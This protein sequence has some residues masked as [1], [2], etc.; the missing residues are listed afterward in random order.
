MSVFSTIFN[1]SARPVL[2]EHLASTVTALFRV[3]GRDDVTVTIARGPERMTEEPDD[4]SGRKTRHRQRV[5]LFSTVDLQIGALLVLDD[6][7]WSIE[8]FV[9]L[10]DSADGFAKLELR[11]AGQ[12]ERTRPGYRR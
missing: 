7:E 11:Q 1:D 6:V 10:P 9:K 8:N 2:S 4:Q 3:P 12:I 5:L